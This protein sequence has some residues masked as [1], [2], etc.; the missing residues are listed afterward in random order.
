MRQRPG[1]RARAVPRG[2]QRGPRV[3]RRGGRRALRRKNQPATSYRM[4][5]SRR[6]R[7]FRQGSIV[8][9]AMAGVM[10]MIF[11]PG[12]AASS[13][14]TT[15]VPGADAIETATRPLRDLANEFTRMLPSI[16]VAIGILLVAALIARL[17]RPLLRRMFG[18]WTR[19]DAATALA[20]IVLW[21]IA[22]ATSL[23]VIA[24]D[25]RALLGSVGLF[26]LALS[27]A[28][29]APIESFA[30]WLLN[31]FKSYYRVGDRILVGDVFGDV[32]AIDVLTTTVW[33]AGGLDKAV[34]GAQPTGALIT[35]PN[36]EVLRSS[37]T[38]YT[39]DFPYVWDEITIGVA[40]E[41]D[42]RLACRVCRDTAGKVL[43]QVMQA[44]AADYQ[45]L[46]MS[47]NLDFDIAVEPQV[48]VTAADEW[49]NLT[50]RYLIPARAR[51]HWAS[52][53][54]LAVNDALAEPDNA[55]RIFTSYPRRQVQVLPLD[56]L[57]PLGPPQQVT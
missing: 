24:G 46:L 6:L 30:G 23:S 54:L 28:L 36:S 47:K 25:A 34:H 15:N 12:S 2:G 44:P 48:F 17:V 16:L 26:G 41:S 43:G 35:F 51:R 13:Q 9:V 8:A 31:S 57:D 5:A 10:L 14:D 3:S 19:A 29:Q 11:A 39:R 40:N 42:V 4:Q 32:Y 21:T 45:A 1:S 50:I 37:I 53:L 7:R 33:E 20:I 38:N 49:T 56:G 55:A 22:I 27:W 18:S 52:E